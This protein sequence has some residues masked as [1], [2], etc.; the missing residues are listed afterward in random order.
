MKYFLYHM[1]NIRINSL[2]ACLKVTL[3]IAFFTF[4]PNNAMSDK[5]KTN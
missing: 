3:K 2:R 1:V 5:R 4:A